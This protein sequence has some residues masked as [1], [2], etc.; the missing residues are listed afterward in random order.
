MWTIRSWDTLSSVENTSCEPLCYVVVLS[1]VCVLHYGHAI[2]NISVYMHS[3]IL[4]FIMEIN[5]IVYY[6]CLACMG[7]IL[8]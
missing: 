1:Q 7:L 2:V 3:C 5:E 6:R 8:M 4:S